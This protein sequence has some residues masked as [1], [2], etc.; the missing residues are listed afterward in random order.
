MNKY[1]VNSTHNALKDRLIDY[2]RAQYLGENQLLLDV[3]NETIEK[4]SVLYQEP[5]IEANPAYKVKVDG[6][7]HADIPDNIK[8]YLLDMS[9]KK[10]GV[11]KNPFSHQILALEKFYQGKDLFVTTGTGSGK[12]ECFLWP[13]VSSILKEAS[14]NKK[15]WEKRGVRALM[16]YPMNALVSDQ[17]GRLRKMIGDVDG[18]FHGVLY[19][20]SGSTDTR[21][22]QFG[23]YTGRSPYPGNQS[24]TEDEQ[25]ASTLRE[26]IVDRPDKIKEKLIEIGKYPAKN[27]LD[28][29]ISD[30]SKGKHNTSPL[31]AELLTRQEIQ[32][33][34]PDILITNYSMLE[35]MLFR[36]L[37]KRIW[38]DTQSWLAEAEENKLLIVIDEAHMYRGS[39]GGEVALLIRRLL[40]KLNIPR[41]KVQFILT[42]AS[43]PQNSED[44]VIEFSCGLTAEDKGKHNFAIIYGENEEINYESS[45]EIEASKLAAISI[46]QFS[47]DIKSKKLAIES[48][49][50]I[51]DVKRDFTNYFDAQFWLYNF[52][53]E[54]K[55]M[56][57]I[58]ENCRGHATS[59]KELASNV[60]PNDDLIT[61]GKALEVLLA[62]APL[63]VNEEKQVLF[64]ARLHMM[65][66]GLKGVYACS[67]PNCHSNQSADGLTLGKI[68]FNN[69][70]DRCDA[71]GSNG[72]TCNGKVYEI[73]NDRRCGALFLK[74]YMI[75]SGRESKFFWNTLGEQ[76][77]ENMKEVYFYLIPEN[78]GYK[79]Q[80]DSKVGYLNALTGKFYENDLYAEKKGFIKVAYSTK[81]NKGKPDI[82]SF[83]TCP[84]CGKSHLNMSDFLTKGNESFYNLVSEQLMI[85]PAQIFDQDKLKKYPNAG[86]KVLLF[87]DSRQR[88]AGLAKD[89]TRS[90]DDDAVRKVVVGAVIKLMDWADRNDKQPTM[91]LLYLPFLEVANA[92][93]LQLFYGEEKKAFNDD[94]KRID[95][96]IM[97][98]K[99]RNRKVDYDSL[100]KYFNTKPDLYEE[101]LLKLLCSSYRSLT[102]IGLCYVL[103]CDFDLEDDIEEVFEDANIDMSLEE[104]KALFSAWAN[105]IMK[106][107]YALGDEIDNAIRE[108]VRP[109]NYNR[110]GISPEKKMPNSLK[111]I[112]RNNN[113]SEGNIEEIYN[114]FCK[115]TAELQGSSNL[116]LNLNLISLNYNF[117]QKWFYCKK[118]SGLFHTTLWNSCAHC[119]DTE[120]IKMTNDDL[121]R[122]D[123]WRKPV[124]EMINNVDNNKITSINTE[125]HT[126]Q[127]SYKDQRQNLWSKTE[128]YEMRFQDVHIDE[129]MP[130]DILSCTTT[131]EVG[132]DI[133]S[134]TA[135]GLRNIPPM[136]ENYQQRAG[137]AGRRSSSIS[138]IV[139]FTDNG[140]HDSYY[141]SNPQ[142]IITGEVR[143]PW[144]DI[145]NIK[146]VKRHINIVM[147]NQFLKDTEYGMDKLKLDAFFGDYFE[148][149]KALLGKDVFMKE[150]ILTL[151]P[152]HIK[153]N[154]K[155]VREELIKN[156]EL[157]KESYEKNPQDY[158]DEKSQFKSL[159]DV[160]YSK[161]ILPTYSFPKDVVGF[162]I[163]DREGNIEKRPDRSLDMAISEY[164]PGRTLVVDKKTYRSGG[165][166]NFHSKYR[167]NHYERP[168]RPY[169]ESK[170][171]FKKMYMC[172]DR[173]CGWFGIEEPK[174]NVCPFCK[175]QGIEHNFLLKPW[176]FAPENG[177]SIP[178]AKAENQVSYAEEPCYSATPDKDDMKSTSFS[179][180]RYAKRSDQTL[181]VLNKGPE[182]KGFNVCKD[183]GAAVPGNQ[184][185]DS[186]KKPYKHKWTS[187]R[188]FHK[189]YENVVL[190]H[191]FNT[192]MVIYEIEIDRSK[193]NVDLKGYW[194]SNAA[195]T[196]SEALVLA[197]GR[198]LD[199]EFNEIKSG[200]RLRYFKD[201]VMVD[202]FLFDSLSS[203]AGYSAA[204]ASRTKELFNATEEILRNCNCDSSCHE[205]LNHFWNQKVQNKL[206]RNAGYELIKW[207]ENGEITNKLSIES[208]R[209]VL[210]P[211]K[212]LLEIEK[213][214]IVSVENNSI[215]IRNSERKRDLYIYP[216]MWN[217]KSNMIPKGDI[218]LS[219]RLIEKALPEAY[220]QVIDN[221]NNL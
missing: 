83:S 99:K 22:P 137:R 163:E 77:S 2:I 156:L 201:K 72:E 181:T 76:Y 66:R 8:R 141:F 121:K 7:K 93:N 61:A 9:N 193:I 104:F 57:R 147:I 173:S 43:V 162:Y 18:N 185:I 142:K 125:E 169:F 124:I 161:S 117:E 13:M 167:K 75:Q 128:D 17:L 79:K 132:I 217:A 36:P 202:I 212:E 29:F 41:S 65:F 44:E 114:C 165:I 27:D 34:C 213:Q 111:K 112:L 205:C 37:E 92:N 81:E 3:C 30:L 10:L 46:D 195:L 5:Y 209:N 70:K 208:Q 157:I 133:G 87:S 192:D 129:A 219:D 119:G 33:V 206:D 145:D 130:I 138:T 166:Y 139:T 140:P 47:K 150:Q 118:C 19:K 20:N 68:Y 50:S 15:S 149:F 184:D 154:L 67:N 152:T 182:E 218:N 24:E 194:I 168:A 55:P 110:F 94:M 134:L 107:S 32:K 172:K 189:E 143:K 51:F 95:S 155:Q 14:C 215:T 207:G 80:K 101:Q 63:A 113:Y 176:G 131:M 39:A 126:A 105:I 56:L 220:N 89:L 35:Y 180:I 21:V 127:L 106:D 71:Q 200:Y 151:I 174:D 178:E 45:I 86:R 48:F 123:F 97:K 160:L 38:E 216:V 122:F 109:T 214:F 103:P 60:F 91:N 23:M 40:H 42:S 115:Y 146:L 108:N 153:C 148:N 74:G 203:G 52:L 54:F 116:Y 64:P 179:N 158:Y 98:A 188:C 25:L 90:A 58:M 120:V 28:E 102:D 11:F 221:F 183:C 197:A 186:V 96:K 62:I 78:R 191:S 1:G 198:M 69:D 210:K 53:S 204:L 73:V 144:I 26:G 187:K 4:E 170:E 6:I 177:T 164:A 85:Q 31:D 59:F 135:V 171:Y 12:T 88:A 82:L 84:K 175:S 190:G 159:M 199:I 16:L 196:L 136:R 100:Q 49:S 211:L